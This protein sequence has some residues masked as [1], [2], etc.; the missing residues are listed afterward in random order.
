MEAGGSALSFRFAALADC[1]ALAELNHQLI[2]DEGHRN[3]MTVPELDQRMRSWLAGEYQAVI[4]EADGGIV[5]YALFREEPEEMYLRQLF[6]VRH[7]RRQGVGRK[8][9]EIL[10][11]QIWPRNKRLTVEVLVA[12]KDAVAFWRA[13]GYRDY[14]LRLE[15][16]PAS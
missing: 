8:A 1:R 13:V 7:K 5:A 15:V 4:F 10:R 11:S 6:V 3:P 2:R 12:N 16:M 14:A 9:V